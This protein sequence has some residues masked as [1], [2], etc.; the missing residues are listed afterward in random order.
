MAKKILKN[1]NTSAQNVAAPDTK[2]TVSKPLAVVLQKCLRF[3]TSA[4]SPLAVKT[5][6]I[7]S[8]TNLKLLSA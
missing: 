8:C 2:A 5:A 3:K 4:L 6:A 1:V 7:Q